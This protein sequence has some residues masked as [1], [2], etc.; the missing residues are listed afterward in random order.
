[1]ERRRLML[2]FRFSSLKNLKANGRPQSEVI[3]LGRPYNFQMSLIYELE[4]CKAVHVV[5]LEILCCTSVNRFATSRIAL[6]ASN[7]GDSPMRSITISL[8]GHYPVGISTNLVFLL[9]IFALLL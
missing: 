3:C 4:T 2:S 8:K 9:C 1:M 5:L 6:Q 7:S